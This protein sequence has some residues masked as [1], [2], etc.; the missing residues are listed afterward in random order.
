MTE[1]LVN[2]K[3]IIEYVR[4]RTGVGREDILI[5]EKAMGNIAVMVDIADN[6]MIHTLDEEIN[7]KIA[8][9]TEVEVKSMPDDG[10]MPNSIGYTG[11]PPGDSAGIGEEV[12]LEIENEDFATSVQDVSIGAGVTPSDDFNVEVEELTG[13]EVEEIVSQSIEDVARNISQSVE[14]MQEVFSSVAEQISDLATELPTKEIIKIQEELAINDFSE[15]DLVA[16]ENTDGTYNYGKI[17]SESRVAREVLVGDD[18]LV[19][20]WDDAGHNI[21]GSE[22]VYKVETSD[23]VLDYP[24]SKIHLG[25]RS[26]SGVGYSQAEALREAGYHRKFDLMRASQSDLSEIDGIGNGLAARIKANIGTVNLFGDPNTERQEIIQCP[27]C[28]KKFPSN[29]A[30]AIEGDDGEL[31]CSL[32][33][34]HEVY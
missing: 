25:V 24:V 4:S 7:D 17:K 10:E 1:E 32:N 23:I 14:S 19:E 29:S 15:G 3:D 9:A 18:T 30:K 2:E 34:L 5:Y 21:E 22:I 13:N 20:Y 27:V 8:A 33:C 26:V 12:T 16:C 6:A 11:P 31:F 28:D